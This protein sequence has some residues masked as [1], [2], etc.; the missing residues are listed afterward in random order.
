M[1]TLQTHPFTAELYKDALQCIPFQRSS[2]TTAPVYKLCYVITYDAVMPVVNRPTQLIC[3]IRKRHSWAICCDA[4]VCHSSVLQVHQQ[5]L[6]LVLKCDDR[7]VYKCSAI[8]TIDS[9][10]VP[11]QWSSLNTVLSG[12]LPS[13]ATAK[14]LYLGLR[15]AVRQPPAKS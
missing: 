3:Q 6:H 9:R 14:L 12:S 7:V 2:M 5:H 8:Y 11:A 13:T 4:S 15:S 10:Y 1:H